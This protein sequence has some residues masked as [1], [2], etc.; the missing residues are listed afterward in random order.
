MPARDKWWDE[1]IKSDT[2]NY[3]RKAELAR[4]DNGSRKPPSSGRGCVK[5]HDSHHFSAAGGASA[6]LLFI[7]C[8]NEH[9]RFVEPRAALMCHWCR[10]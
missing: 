9:F 5:T 4:K 10:C 1:V 6:L 2:A 7:V 3:Y 8:V